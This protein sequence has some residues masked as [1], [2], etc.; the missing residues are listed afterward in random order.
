MAGPGPIVR[1]LI[2]CDRVSYRHGTGYTLVNPWVELR[3]QAGERF[4]LAV[5]EAWVFFQ[6]GGSYG[7]HRFRVRLVDVTDP[8]GPPVTVFET[9]ERA[10]HLGNP[11][12]RY[13]LR[14]RG[15]SLRLTTVPFPRPGRYEVWVTFGGV[16]HARLG[17]LVEG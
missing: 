1:Q 17:V 11:T 4:P 2:V 9:P 16:P 3:A 15:W 5:A 6:V 7:T 10:I 13:R 12:G 8:T 14:S